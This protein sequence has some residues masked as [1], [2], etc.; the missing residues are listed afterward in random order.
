MFLFFP[1]LINK[2]ARQWWALK[3]L[4]LR[5]FSYLQKSVTLAAALGLGKGAVQPGI[6]EEE[7]TREAGL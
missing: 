1:G 7:L 2:F 5:R 3:N 4:F 6:A